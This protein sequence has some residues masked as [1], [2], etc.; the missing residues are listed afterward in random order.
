MPVSAFT[1]LSNNIS[2]S[3]DRTGVA[4]GFTP[5][6]GE[7]DLSPYPLSFASSVNSNALDISNWNNLPQPYT[8]SI[9]DRNGTPV[10]GFSDFELPLAPQNIMQTEMFATSI[11]PTQGGTVVTHS[12]NKYKSLKISGTTG[13][14]PFRGVAGVNRRTGEAY[15]T[16]GGLKFKSGYEVFIEL[17]NF[18]KAYY[19]FKNTGQLDKNARIVWKNYKDGEFLVIEL[20]SFNM[21]RAAGRPF[22]Y[23][24][25]ID[26]KVLKAF[27]FN[28]PQA[29]FLSDLEN[30]INDAVSKIEAAR[31]ALLGAQ[32]ALRQVE[33][34]FNS[35][36][37]EPLRLINLTVK[38]AVGTALTLA[39][40]GTRIITNTFALGGIT[41]LLVSL[42]A[43]QEEQKRN[44]GGSV[45][46]QNANLPTDPAAAAASLG[47]NAL[48]DLGPLLQ[49]VDLGDAPQATRDAAAQEVAE[50]VLPQQFYTDA[51]AALERVKNNFEDFVGLSSDTYDTIF[52]RTSTVTADTGRVTTNDE[53][54]ILNAFNIA[55]S[56]IQDL[57]STSVL[58]RTSYE[59]EIESLLAAFN[60][61]IDLQAEGAVRE[62]T[63]PGA[64]TLEQLALQYL[65]D[66]KRWPEIAILN[67]LK[68]PYLCQSERF[69][70]LTR[71]DGTV[72]TNPN[73]LTT[74]ELAMFNFE[75][76][77]ASPG[78]SILI[79]APV[80]FG[81]GETPLG[82]TTSIT[83]DLN[84]VEKNIGV[85]L[86]VDPATFD[87]ILSNG[88][89]LE[90]IA[91][92]GN[93][94]QAIILKL[95]YQKGELLSN[96]EIGVGLIVGSKVRDLNA[97]R[98]DVT[99]SLLQDPRI[100][101]I[102]GFTIARDG[103]ELR[104]RFR[105]N[106]KQ[107]DQPVPIELALPVR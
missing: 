82:A 39:D 105:A 64:T 21:K 57:I 1:Q 98:D 36:I 17:R 86:R 53:F 33:S 50:T 88:G 49:E 22:L 69:V 83:Q 55:I 67:G 16:P 46:L 89:D 81:F 79:P 44:G 65:A 91:A 27:D 54:D 5:G 7:N 73:L 87:M 72:I 66:A 42:F 61:T 32:G 92:A 51:I 24:Y 95:T 62:I 77:V 12:G 26:C 34:T 11:K 93:M 6:G 106:I 103:P 20:M 101:G 68:P 10:A 25:D 35:T 58:F 96:P 104:L 80:I 14:A 9:V 52:G 97:I 15:F 84:Q 38:T 90:A 37:L 18:F 29:G 41:A 71:T 70:S 47:A 107:V 63:L 102:D 13:I 2:A 8:F 78:D 45:T 4:L 75:T 19:E 3:L 60:D 100:E 28:P 99:R 74:D 56:G 30:K 40:V 23:D 59:D 43:A 85:D 94:A 31:G 48:I 76:I